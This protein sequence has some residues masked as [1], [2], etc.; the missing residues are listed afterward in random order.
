MRKIKLH[1]ALDNDIEDYAIAELVIGE[2]GKL[3]KLETGG[4]KETGQTLTWSIKAGETL[5]FPFYVADI[6]MNRYG[7][8]DLEA[9]NRGMEVVGESEE[10]VPAKPK[11]G[12][13]VCKTCG[14]TFK[15]MRGLGLHI[16]TKHP[17]KLK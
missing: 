15:N 4:Y 17:D 9:K 12:G 8:K 16:A 14:Q 10:E 13:V 3:I 2:D 6:L 5:E 7:Q 1:N 11:D